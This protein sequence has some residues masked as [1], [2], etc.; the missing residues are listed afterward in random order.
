V[1][2][3]PFLLLLFAC[4]VAA[5]QPTRPAATQPAWNINPDLPTIFL[6]G[7]STAQNGDPLHTGWGKTF[8]DYVDR[9]RANWV[10]AAR[11]G[12]SSRTYVTE[13]LWNRLLSN[14]KPGDF[15]FIHFGHND[16]GAVNH[17]SRARGSLPGLGDET[18]EIDNQVTGNH[19]GK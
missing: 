6:A 13:G 3:R 2:F 11:G 17:A 9:T 16:G 7:D 19:A 15:V 12:R 10:N 1:N 5:A 4:S 14:L 18:Q 8:G